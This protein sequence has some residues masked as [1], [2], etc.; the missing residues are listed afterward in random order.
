MSKRLISTPTNRLI[1]RFNV[2]HELLSFMDTYSRYNKIKMY[3]LDMEVTFFVIDRGTH[4][5]KIMP[6]GLKNTRATY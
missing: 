2:T 5:Y 6:F 4:C 1:G 3:E